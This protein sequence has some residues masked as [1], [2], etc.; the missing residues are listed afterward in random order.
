MANFHVKDS[1]RHR[2]KLRV[3]KPQLAQNLAS[4]SDA[5]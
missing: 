1:A 5:A 4:F 3:R 2:R